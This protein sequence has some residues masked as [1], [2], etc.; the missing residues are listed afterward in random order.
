GR[1]ILQPDGHLDRKR[2]GALVFADA[3]RRRRLEQIT[4]PAIRQRQQRILSVLE[5]EEFEGIVIW[6]VGLLF[7]PGGVDQMARVIVADAD[8]ARGLSRL[9]ARDGSGEAE[10]RRR[11]GS[12]MPVAEKAER[13]HYVIDNSGTRADT[14][15]QVR[16]VYRALLD[17][18]R[19]LTPPV[20]G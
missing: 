14:E 13:A 11:I 3:D 6:D 5:E 9:M 15:R 19:T 1:E 7:G 4:H 16:Q 20:R 18:L 17:D 8:A 2:L 10:A 12:Q